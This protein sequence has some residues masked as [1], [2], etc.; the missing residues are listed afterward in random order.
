[1]HIRILPAKTP[2]LYQNLSQKAIELHLLGLSYN[3]IGKAL[4]IDPKTAAKAI[5]QNNPKR[6]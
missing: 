4:G 1:V 5:S 6:R 2:Y 3:Q